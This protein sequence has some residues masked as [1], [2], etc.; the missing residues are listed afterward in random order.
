MQDANSQNLK[1]QQ[2]VPLLQQQLAA[3]Q[4]QQQ[5]VTRDTYARRLARDDYAL[6][7]DVSDAIPPHLQMECMEGH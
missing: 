5:E 7:P 4:Q 6:H 1:L 3:I 2:T